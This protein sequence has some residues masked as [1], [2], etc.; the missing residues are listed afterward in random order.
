MTFEQYLDKYGPSVRE[1]AGM[2]CEQRVRAASMAYHRWINGQLPNS[3]EATIDFRRGLELG[4][5][6]MVF[7]HMM[8][9]SRILAENNEIK[10]P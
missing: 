6:I 7:Q 10:Q 9:N 5:E 3:L 2:S 4:Q 8:Q 1:L